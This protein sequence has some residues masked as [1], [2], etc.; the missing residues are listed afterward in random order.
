MTLESFTRRN[1][2]N[3]LAADAN[4]VHPFDPVKHAVHGRYSSLRED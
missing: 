1:V 2:W 3:G 4:P